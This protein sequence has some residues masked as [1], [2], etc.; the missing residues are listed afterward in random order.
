MIDSDE[1]A[2][3]MK[4]LFARLSTVQEENEDL[5]N[6]QYQFNLSEYDIIESFQGIFTAVFLSFIHPSVLTVFNN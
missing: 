1:Y 4:R 3:R 2:K 6:E 5:I